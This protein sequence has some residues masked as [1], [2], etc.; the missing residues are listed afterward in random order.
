MPQQFDLGAMLDVLGWSQAELARRVDVHPN[1]VS[2][3]STG[4]TNVPGPVR[5]YLELAVK[6]KGL[7]E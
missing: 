1:T 6:A 2:G 4:R 5:A 3:W 7:L